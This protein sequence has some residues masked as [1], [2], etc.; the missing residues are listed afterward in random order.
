MPKN[1]SHS[2]NEPALSGLAVARRCWT[3]RAAFDFVAPI[4]PSA[5]Q[6]IYQSVR[7]F[8]RPSEF[9]RSV[10]HA[11]RAGLEFAPGRSSNADGGAMAKQVIFVVHGMGD[12]KSG[13]C[14]SIAKLIKDLYNGYA[15]AKLLPFDEQFEVK[16]VTYNDFFDKLRAAWAAAASSVVDQMK[17][18]GGNTGSALTALNKLATTANKNDFL[19]T[20][21]L[22]VA[23]YRF[24]PT[25]ADKVHASVVS[26]I[27][28]G[29]KGAEQWSV[30]GHSLG[31]SVLHDSLVW[32]FDPN[33]PKQLK[34]EKFRFQTTAMVANVSRL[35]EPSEYGE[36]WDVYR[37]VVQPNAD[38]TKGACNRF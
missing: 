16:P 21:L 17:F 30:I 1:F 33:S 37:S 12:F 19:Q 29:I 11:R 35:L 32:M 36:V 14:V 34:P 38:V 2:L 28:A 20:H 13:W 24:V 3:L 22:D 8:I 26:Q 6:S 9:A 31:S 5:A 10:W 15:V 4:A 18:V 27:L 7:R 23:L 25:V